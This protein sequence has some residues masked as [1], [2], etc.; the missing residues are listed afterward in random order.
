MILRKVNFIRDVRAK[1]DFS[2]HLFVVYASCR[3]IFKIYSYF[4]VHH[5]VILV[6]IL[7]KMLYLHAI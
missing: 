1:R 4:R 5:P 3:Y 7:K 2:I 6:Y